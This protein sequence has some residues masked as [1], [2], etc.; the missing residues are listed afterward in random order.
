MEKQIKHKKKM[1]FKTKREIN[2]LIFVLPWL[3]GLIAF[4][5]IPLVQTFIMS[6]SA[7]METHFEFN[8]L[9][10]YIFLF[11]DFSY[12]MNGQDYSFIRVILESLQ[13]I[14]LELPI[15]IIFSLFVAVLL[16]RKFKGRG[17]V[18]TI[19]FLPII[20][21][22]S[23]ITQ[24]TQ[25]NATADYFTQII[26]SQNLYQQLDIAYLFTGS[27]IPQAMINTLA[28]AVGRV[29]QIV[30]FSGVQILIFLSALQSINPT[31]Y[32]VAKIEG[33][34]SYEVFW[35]ITLPSITPII[36]TAVVYTFIDVLYRSPMTSVIGEVSKLTQVTGG[37]FG[38]AS[39]ISVIFLLITMILLGLILLL[40]R[41]VENGGKN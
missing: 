39:S 38:I 23:I 7:D 1:K 26:G 8:G 37:G 2:A 19:F 32:E 28:G 30:A 40:L 14:L 31:L 13:M 27:G 25:S 20:F 21:G 10:N 4:F 22:A 41:R 33:A 29:F 16:N 6:F 3:I 12:V 17:L 36:I 5:L 35:K 15:I 18:R 9:D 11:K 24:L 34:N